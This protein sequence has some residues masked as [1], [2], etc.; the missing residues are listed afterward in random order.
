VIE[1]LRTKAAAGATVRELVETIQQ[2]LSYPPD[3]VV[4][5][6]AHMREAFCVSLLDVLPIREWLGSNDDRAIDSLVMPAIQRTRSKWL[7]AAE[8]MVAAST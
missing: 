4:G 2:R 5:V 3:A 1:E 7:H 8:P 6:L